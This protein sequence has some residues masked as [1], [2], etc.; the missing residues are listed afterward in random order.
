M[1]GPTR[2]SL[3]KRSRMKGRGF[4]SYW[5]CKYFHHWKRKH[6]GCGGYIIKYYSIVIKCRNFKGF[7]LS[8][9]FI[10]LW[11]DYG[12]ARG[13]YLEKIQNVIHT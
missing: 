5:K 1:M 11:F 10:E 9:G 7:V 2:L 8:Q 3:L 6:I 13:T 4:D 12:Y